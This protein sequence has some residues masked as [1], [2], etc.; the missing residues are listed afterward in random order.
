MW[1]DQ[2]FSLHDF[3]LKPQIKGICRRVENQKIVTTIQ[4][5]FENQKSQ[6]DKSDINIHWASKET[7]H[8]FGA[9]LTKIHSI[10]MNHIHIWTQI[11]YSIPYQAH[12]KKQTVCF[13]QKEVKWGE[14]TFQK[15]HKLLVSRARS[16]AHLQ[17]TVWRLHND[18][19]PLKLNE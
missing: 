18:N 6:S 19:L 4:Q 3:I 17:K 8:F 10:N 14:I 12:L 2:N 1:Q 5:C 13:S 7:Y 16:S 9:T 11:N 15:S